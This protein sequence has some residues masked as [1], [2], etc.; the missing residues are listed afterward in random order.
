MKKNLLVF[1]ILCSALITE[2]LAQGR[3]VSGRIISQDDG[4]VGFLSLQNTLIIHRVSWTLTKYYFKF[5]I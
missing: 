5:E 1:F 3:T 2:S 4:K